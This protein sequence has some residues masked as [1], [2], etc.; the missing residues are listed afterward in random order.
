MCHDPPVKIEPEID[1]SQP[2]FDKID[3]AAVGAFRVVPEH[4]EF[5]TDM[6]HRLHERRVFTRSGGGWTQ[7]LLYP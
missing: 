6:P 2:I 1:E 7:G 4:F 3:M 5:W